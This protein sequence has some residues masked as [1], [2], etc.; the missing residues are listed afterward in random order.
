[1]FN[2]DGIVREQCWFDARHVRLRYFLWKR[3]GACVAAT[4]PGVAAHR[5]ALVLVHGFSQQADSWDEVARALAQDRV[6]Y[7]LELTGHGES[8][9]PDQARFYQ[10]TCQAEAL[11]RFMM[12]EAVARDGEKPWVLG[13]SM[14][15]RVAVQAAVDTPEAFGGLLLESAGL[16]PETDDERR[17]A[18]ARDAAS[19]ARLRACGIERFM[20]EWEALPLFASQRSL[21]GA[22]CARLRESR[23]SNDAEALARTF[24]QAGQHAMPS[25]AAVL[26]ALR[27]M[28]SRR[29]PFSYIAG[30]DDV[31]YA[32]L[33]EVLAAA[34]FCAEVVMGSGHNVHEER[35]S[36]FVDWVRAVDDMRNSDALRTGVLP[37]GF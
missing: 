22:R 30:A 31:K 36:A 16:G 25:R 33:G 10:L 15:G 24:E 23:C 29:I 21:D 4:N 20:D 28:Q 1:M 6:V 26:R 12:Q 17:A 37:N 14:G 7:A 18:A 8:E 34:G 32:R 11:V 5:P 35:P 2:H 19:A 9:R 13:Y 27:D 3:A